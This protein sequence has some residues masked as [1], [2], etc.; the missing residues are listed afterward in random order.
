[1]NIKQIV[2]VLEGGLTDSARDILR[3]YGAEYPAMHL[4]FQEI[5]EITVFDLLSG[6]QLDCAIVA[7]FPEVYRGALEG[8]VIESY[9]I[10]AVVNR[11]H[12]LAQR[13]SLSVREL[14]DE[15]F[16][17]IDEEKSV[18]GFQFTMSLCLKNGF[19]PRVA[20]KESSV[21]M[22]LSAVDLGFGV[23]ILADS[24]VGS[25]GRHTVF[26]PL[27]DLEPGQVWLVRRKDC[28]NT[29]M[30]NFD[31]FLAEQTGP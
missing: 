24:M 6:G 2:G 28:A 4:S 12:P 7:H 30:L 8:Q 18:M 31:A 22:A 23:M 1:M 16:I 21:S 3:R 27:E 9:R 5:S 26:I 10:C 29:A 25:G 15:G 19:S 13:P 20:R 14:K 17:L 11:S